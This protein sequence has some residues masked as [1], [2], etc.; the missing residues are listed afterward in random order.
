LFELDHERDNGRVVGGRLGTC[1]QQPPV[2]DLIAPAVPPYLQ[3]LFDHPNSLTESANAPL[4]LSTA[5]AGIGRTAGKRRTVED[6][7]IWLG[8][9]LVSQLL[10]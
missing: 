8:D 6:Y 2:H 1:H 7:E 9:T 5:K 4:E 3:S 10:R